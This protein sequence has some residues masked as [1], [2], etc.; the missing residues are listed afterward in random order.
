MKADKMKTATLASGRGMIGKGAEG[1]SG[2]VGRSVIAAVV[3]LALMPLIGRSMVADATDVTVNV[4]SLHQVIDGFGASSAWCGT[5]PSVVMN[6]LYGDLGFSILRVRIEEGIG[7]ANWANGP[8][9]SWAPELANAQSANSH[10]AIV[11]ATPWNPP[12]GLRLTG[13]GGEY[14]IDTT[15]W[16]SYRD[17]LNAYVK[18]FKTNGVNL[19]AISMQNEPDYSSSWTYWSPA[20]IH[21]FAL[22]YG[23]SVTTKLISGESFT[24]NKPYY[25]PILNDTKALA[26]VAIF[27]THIYGTSVANYAYPLFQQIGVP[28]GKKLWM[29][30]HYL[31]SDDN[32]TTTIMPVAKEIHDWLVTGNGDA[33]IYWWITYG[34]GLATSSGTIYKRAY[35]ISQFA[36]Y[37]RPGYHRV[38]ATA[39]PATNVYVSAYAGADSVVIVAIN[40]GTSAASQTFTLQNASV[41]QF[42]SWNTT[43]NTNMAAGSA[44]AVSGSSFTASLP[45]QSIT[46]FVGKNTSTSVE[47]RSAGATA[48]QEFKARIAGGKLV[49]TPMDDSRTY[50]ATVYALDG[51]QAVT[52]NGSR[53]VLEIPVNAKGMYV[54]NIESDGHVQRELVPTF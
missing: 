34:N 33:Y 25:D 10:G 9:T 40:T 11:F 5:I 21:N 16:A 37:I 2:R 12:P 41:S 46:T 18:Y 4:S 53:G 47:S 23:A 45:A 7:D 38:D 50:D 32:I 43:A 19:Y 8:Y 28:A 49:I 6:S 13:G 14:S 3:G 48:A 52:R 36:K 29:T 44:A 22:E 17:Y 51:R 15:K 26:N 24:F 20:Q 39:N 54:V 1:A 35:V 27:G 42:S 30:E 31:N